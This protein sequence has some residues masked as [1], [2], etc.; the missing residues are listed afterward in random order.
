MTKLVIALIKEDEPKEKITLHDTSNSNTNNMMS[1]YSR[2][3]R[4]ANWLA[5]WLT[6]RHT[7]QLYA[8][9][10]IP[11][12]RKQLLPATGKAT[13]AI[14]SAMPP[15]NAWNINRLS[16]RLRHK[17]LFFQLVFCPG[18]FCCCSCC[19]LCWSLYTILC[20]SMLSGCS[21]GP[22]GPRLSPLC[23]ACSLQ[24]SHRIIITSPH[25]DGHFVDNYLPN[26]MLQQ[27]SMDDSGR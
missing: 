16:H 24:H 4:P 3:L 7:E 2:F 1:N 12:Q 18:C 26:Y 11:G 13:Q 8:N 25:S 23:S 14:L 5:D 20:H 10:Q 9:G 21:P 27:T 19:V 22:L 17:Y 6:T 15:T